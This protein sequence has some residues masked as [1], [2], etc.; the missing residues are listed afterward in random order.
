MLGIDDIGFF[1]SRIFYGF[2]FLFFFFRFL[3]NRYIEFPIV[4][5][6]S[7]CIGESSGHYGNKTV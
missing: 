6:R 1:V 7:G 5:D 2:F 3:A 4:T